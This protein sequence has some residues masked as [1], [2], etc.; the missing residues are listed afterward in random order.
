[1]FLLF[2]ARGYFQVPCCFRG[3]YWMLLTLMHFLPIQLAWRW[4]IFKSENRLNTKN[5]MPAQK[6]SNTS[7]GSKWKNSKKN[8]LGTM[9]KIQKVHQLVWK[10]EN[11]QLEEKLWRWKD[12][13]PFQLGDW[14]LVSVS[15]LEERPYM[16]EK[17]C[18]I[19]HFSSSVYQFLEYPNILGAKY[20]MNKPSWK[21]TQRFSEFPRFICETQ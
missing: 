17:T 21:N 4:S 9:F 19:V 20:W 14:G 18:K 15:R 11:S 6:R 13:F 5:Q 1:M 2:L 3:V 8:L 7:W 10:S 16:K 12:D